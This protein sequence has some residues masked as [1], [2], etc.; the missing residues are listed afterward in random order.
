MKVLLLA[1]FTLREAL[2]RRVLL[3]I[4]ILTILFVGVYAL[5]T[6]FAFQDLKTSTRIP[7]QLVSVY[8]SQIVLA[9][10]YVT[11]FIGVLLAIFTSVG[12]I[13]GEIEA[14]TLQAIVPKPIKRWEIVL[15]KW[16]GFAAL[17]AIYVAVTSGTVILVAFLIG[18]YLPPNPLAGMAIIIFEALLLLSMS[19]LGGTVFSTVANGIAVFMLYAIGTVGGM[20]ELLGNLIENNAM[21]NIGIASSLLIP[22]DALYKLAAN[23]LTP[24]AAQQF[25]AAVPFGASTNPSIWMLVYSIFYAIAAVYVAT[26]TFANRDL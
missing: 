12:T 20:I 7:P 22:S 4:L 21:Q 5:G 2:R 8:A 26:T 1:S 19:I 24:A 18:G 11:N 6:Y 3:G 15:G 16:L 17:L 25:S 23:Y 14:G 10:L 13:S 9:G